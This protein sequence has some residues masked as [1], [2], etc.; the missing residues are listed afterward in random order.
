MN[1]E[2]DEKSI[3]CRRLGH[4]VPFHYCRTEG[5]E[6]PC[7]LLLDCWWESFDVVAWA[8]ENLDPEIA[9]ELERRPP[10]PDKRINLFELIEQ[11]KK[12]LEK[13]DG[14]IE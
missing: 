3:R 12:R 4:P 14:P 10:P 11:A 9:A 2:H 7:R 5:G 13:K 1:K 6:K 8:R